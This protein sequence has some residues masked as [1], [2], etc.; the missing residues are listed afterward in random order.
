MTITLNLSPEREAQVKAAAAA[1]G[2]DVNEYAVA[3]TIQAAERDTADYV[4]GINEG[5]ADL[6]AG[7]TVSLE[8]DKASWEQRKTALLGLPA[9]VK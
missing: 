6:E 4:G 7:R 8:E 2:Q 1:A 3:A 9:T 5:F